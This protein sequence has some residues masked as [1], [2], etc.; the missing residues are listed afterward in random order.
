MEWIW[1][2]AAGLLLIVIEMIVLDLVLLMFAGGALAAT[3]ASALGAPLWG[4][5]LAFA[6][7][8]AVLLPSLR[9]WL[10]RHLRRRTVLPETNAAGQVGRT[11]VVVAEVTE[12]AGRIKLFGEVWTARSAA[13]GTTYPV[14][15]EVRVVR[16]EGA[17]AVVQAAPAPE[18]PVRPASRN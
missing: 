11:A 7:V 10:L 9:P 4:Q 2:L 3:V 8:S 12:H 1:W 5:V 17:T 16:I 13:D 14:G 15:T 6:V 18:S